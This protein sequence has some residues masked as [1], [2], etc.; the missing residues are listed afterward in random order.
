MGPVWGW[1]L[2]LALW[3]T[4]VYMF[5]SLTVVV[6]V[7]H[8]RARYM[9]QTA[10]ATVIKSWV[11]EQS[12]DSSVSHRPAV[13]YTFEANGRTWRGDQFTYDPSYRGGGEQYALSYVNKAPAGA[14]L[15]VLYNPDDPSDSVL[16]PYAPGSTYLFFMV[17][18]P[19]LLAEPLLLWGFVLRL[20]R[21]DE[22]EP[23]TSR[24]QKAWRKKAARNSARSWGHMN[25]DSG[26]YFIRGRL[27][28]W[29]KSC[30]ILVILSLLVG[31]LYIGFTGYIVSRHVAMTAWWIVLGLVALDIV[32]QIVL[33]NPMFRVD[34]TRLKVTLR[35]WRRRDEVDFKDIEA[36]GVR[37]IALPSLW[38]S[39]VR[40]N[41]L[42]LYVRTKDGRE[43]PVHVFNGH[44]SGISEAKQATRNLSKI[45]GGACQDPG[46]QPP[47]A[48]EHMVKHAEKW[49]ALSVFAMFR[50]PNIRGWLAYGD[51]C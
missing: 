43:I 25:K 21:G 20:R 26:G 7:K 10:T 17:S 8:M 18:V 33:R 19:F 50:I 27:W 12:G 40:C 41:V 30:L 16:E 35:S 45:T 47:K 5:A 48:I 34:T 32:C 39:F 15:P 46:P 24:S 3:S 14:Q 31:L 2:G 37:W 9:F 23:A 13:E 51:L 1:L 4:I 42:L 11:D 38:A 49:K 22:T 29:M 36:W 28:S 6:L 44:D